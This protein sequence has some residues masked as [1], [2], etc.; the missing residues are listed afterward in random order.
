MTAPQSDPHVQCFAFPY[1]HY[2]RQAHSSDKNW[3]TAAATTLVNPVSL[4]RGLSDRQMINDIRTGLLPRLGML[5]D[6]DSAESPQESAANYVKCRKGSRV[7]FCSTT[8][9]GEWLGVLS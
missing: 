5:K 3:P 2:R 8:V 4:F 1:L 9:S 7:E 6:C